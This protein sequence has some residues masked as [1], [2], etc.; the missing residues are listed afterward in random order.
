MSKQKTSTA[1]AKLTPALAKAAKAAAKETLTSPQGAKPASLEAKDTKG[2][3]ATP[4]AKTGGTRAK[5][6]GCL[7]AAVKVLGGVGKPM[8]CQDIVKDALA[9]RLWQTKGKTPA[10]TLYAAIIREIAAKGKDARFHKTD[11]GLFELSAA[12]K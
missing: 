11:R 6:M 4:K 3:K 1:K 2:R 8:H 10:A 9:N 12:G 7:D 5:K